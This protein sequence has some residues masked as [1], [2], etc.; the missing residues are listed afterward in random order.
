MSVLV[1]AAHPDDEVLGCGGTISRLTQEGQKVYVAIMGEGLTS[2]YAEKKEADTEMVERLHECSRKVSEALGVCE[3][4]MHSLPDNRFD[5]VPLL[6]IVKIVEELI[7]EIKPSI[8]YTHHAGDLNVDHSLLSRA[9]LTATRPVPDS[10]VK[11]VYAFEIPSST[12]WSFQHLQPSFRPN[13]FF[14][15]SKH[16]DV[17][18][19]AMNM[20]DAEVRPFPHPRSSEALRAIAAKWGSTVGLR[21]AEAFELIR[22]TV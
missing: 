17:K 4:S 22:S 14:D 13:T 1:V 7:E 16:I 5:T 8:V 20:Y 6:D 21:A 18:V 2:R 10:V 19:D 3:L 15:I 9:V 12:E 11:T